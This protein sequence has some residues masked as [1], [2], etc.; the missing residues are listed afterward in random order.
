MRKR[1]TRQNAAIDGEHNVQKKRDIR[2]E[3]RN[4]H[5][6]VLLQRMPLKVNRV[7]RL[8]QHSFMQS[9]YKLYK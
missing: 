2:N 6:H 8:L 4:P 5:Y 9:H 7:S 1:I 3:T